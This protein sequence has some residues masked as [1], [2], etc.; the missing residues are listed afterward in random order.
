MVVALLLRKPQPQHIWRI[1]LTIEMELIPLEYKM[2]QID[3]IPQYY[4]SSSFFSLALD[5]NNINK[6]LYTLPVV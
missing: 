6:K 3:K 2:S 5:H 1:L 4:I